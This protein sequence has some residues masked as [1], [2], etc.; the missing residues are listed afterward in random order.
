MVIMAGRALFKIRNQ[1]IRTGVRCARAVAAQTGVIAACTFLCEMGAMIKL[2]DAVKVFRQAN[3]QDLITCEKVGTRVF[4]NLMT[5][6]AATP[7]E[8]VGRFISGPL[9]C[10]DICVGIALL[11]CL[12]TTG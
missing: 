6:H 7:G 1:Q 9:L 4:I 5:K 2:S 3:R 10:A 12:V 8:L 11:A